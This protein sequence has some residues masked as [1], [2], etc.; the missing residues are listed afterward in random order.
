MSPPDPTQTEPESSA[1]LDRQDRLAAHRDRLLGL[2]Y[3]LAGALD[4]GS[5]ERQGLLQLL[6]DALAALEKDADLPRRSI[7]P[8]PAP[9]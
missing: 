6:E 3:A 4:P 8:R 7:E 5:N 1:D 9:D 2:R